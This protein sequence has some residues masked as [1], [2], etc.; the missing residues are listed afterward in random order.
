MYVYLCCAIVGGALLIASLALGGHHGAADSHGGHTDGD[1]ASPATLLFSLRFWTYLLAFGGAVGLALRGLAGT[2]E[3]WCGLLAGGVGLASG[4]VAQVVMTRLGGNQ[5]GG[6][7][8]AAELVGKTGQLLLAVGKGQSGTVRVSVGN[9][10]VDLIAVSDDE[11][12]AAREEVLIV[13]VK[14]GTA[15]VTRNPAHK[16]A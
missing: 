5:R 11:T 1:S 2:S 9:A 4:I 16:G 6:T 15:T 3:P 12:L 10:L 7:V 14:D 13:D 8:Q